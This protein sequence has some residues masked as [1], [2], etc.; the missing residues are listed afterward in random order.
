MRVP[1]DAP[2]GVDTS[3]QT[4]PASLPGSGARSGGIMVSSWYRTIL[5]AVGVLFLLLP[6]IVAVPG[7]INEILAWSSRI[8]ERERARRLEILIIGTFLLYVGRHARARHRRDSAGDGP[9][10]AL[11]GRPGQQ[12]LVP[13]ERLGSDR[14]GRTRRS[15]PQWRAIVPRSRCSLAAAW[16]VR[17]GCS[18]RS[19]IAGSRLRVARA[20]AGSASSGRH[21]RPAPASRRDLGDVRR[22]G[23]RSHPTSRRR[24]PR[25]VGDDPRASPT[26]A[27]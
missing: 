1:L 8:A 17:S 26:F 15:G 25:H 3:S 9:L 2:R 21:R 6:A 20:R 27:G 24:A 4:A 7:N 5:I 23:R 13:R 19:S 18:M 14:D 16:R 10:A 12:R 22:P 11:D